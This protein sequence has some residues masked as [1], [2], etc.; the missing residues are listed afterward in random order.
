MK[1]FKKGYKV[2]AVKCHPVTGD[3]SFIDR[4]VEILHVATCHYVIQG[5]YGRHCMT[6]ND[7]ES[8][9]FVKATKKMIELMTKENL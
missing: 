9:G 1:K 3:R 2:I 7:F 6:F 8:R 5:Q 4:P